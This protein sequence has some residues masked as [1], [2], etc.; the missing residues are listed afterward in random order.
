MNRRK[1]SILEPLKPMISQKIKNPSSIWLWELPRSDSATWGSNPDDPWLMN[2]NL[3]LREWV[4]IDK[5][6]LHE[7]QWKIDQMRKKKE[8]FETLPAKKK[9]K[10][11]R[12]FTEAWERERECLFARER[13]GRALLGEFAIVRLGG[14]IIITHVINYD[15]GLPRG[16][17]WLVIVL[18]TYEQKF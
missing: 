9:K 3:T 8:K 17:M 10:K 16:A 15:L 6:K 4:E 1:M 5:N 11:K 2:N 18:I 13:G 14:T 7:Q 12:R